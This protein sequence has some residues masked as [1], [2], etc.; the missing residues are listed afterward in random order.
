MGQQQRQYENRRKS[1]GANDFVSHFRSGPSTKY[2]KTDTSR[3]LSVADSIRLDARS[4]HGGGF[5]ALPF[6]FCRLF[7][8]FRRSVG[9]ASDK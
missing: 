4:D 2:G 3:F 6:R 5:A 7:W 1:G 8:I 9:N